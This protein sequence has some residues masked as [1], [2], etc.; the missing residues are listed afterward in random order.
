VPRRRHDSLSKDLLSLWLEPLVEVQSSRRVQGEERL[1]DLVCTPRPARGEAR[2]HRKQL[3]LLGRMAKGLT[4]FEAFR[5]PAT[6]AELRGCVV[7]L[8][9]LHEELRRRARRQGQSAARVPLPHLWALTPTLSNGLL[10][11]FGAAPEAGLPEGC[12][13]LAPEL[14]TTVVVLARLPVMP[15]TLWL[16]LLGRGEVQQQAFDDLAA[17][18]AHHPLHSATA[19]RVLRWRTEASRLE[20]LDEA[21]KELLMN[22]ERLVEQWEKRLRD[23]GKAEGEA[24]GKAEAVLVVLEGRGLRVS[25]ATRKHVLGCHDLAQ[26]DAWLRRAATV[27]S[28]RAL[29]D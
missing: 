19:R 13:A 1:V 12:F 2:G 23:E 5:N 21:D 28:A 20:V 16:R 25:V 3:G 26:L 11:G 8:I 18:P 6:A 22:S 29:F 27:A 24:K 17:L 10:E 4:A 15:G 14:G 7:K 9:E